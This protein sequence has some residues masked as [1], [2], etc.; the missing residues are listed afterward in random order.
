MCRDP[1]PDFAGVE[2]SLQAQG[3][4]ERPAAFGK[5][6]TVKDRV[7]MCSPAGSPGVLV[8]YDATGRPAN[9]GNDA[10]KIRL[11]RPLSATHTGADRLRATHLPSSL[12]RVAA[13]A[14]TTSGYWRRRTKT[15][16]M[17]AQFVRG[18]R[19]ARPGYAERR[20]GSVLTDLLPC[21]DKLGQRRG[22]R[23]LVA[24]AALLLSREQ[25]P[26]ESLPSR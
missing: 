6:K 24:T 25:V 14:P 5:V 4:R 1:R 12:P 11:R 19:I 7:H 13:Q 15:N 3:P 17:E 21:I 23:Y 8:G 22:S 9:V 26:L 10:Q 20:S 18:G 16:C 2:R